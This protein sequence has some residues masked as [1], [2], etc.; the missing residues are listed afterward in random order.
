MNDLYNHISS[1]FRKDY[2]TN[3]LVS[4]LLQLAPHTH[5]V[6]DE[7]RMQQGKLEANGVMGIQSIANL[8]NNQQIKCNFQYYEIDYNV[9][10]PVLILSEGRSMLPVS[11]SL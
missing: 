5:L 10:I 9:D 4:G 1:D 8:I 7:T 6:L 11:T 3:K 2:E